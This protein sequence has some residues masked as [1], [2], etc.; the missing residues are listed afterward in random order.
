MD[1]LVNLF[2]LCR[3][4]CQPLTPCTNIL[5]AGL[6]TATIVRINTVA[7]LSLSFTH[8]VFMLVIDFTGLFDLWDAYTLLLVQIGVDDTVSN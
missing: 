2:I 8:T 5:S 6:S 7:N 4:L 1:C 3:F